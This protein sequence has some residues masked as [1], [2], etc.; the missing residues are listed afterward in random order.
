MNYKLA[1]RPS[2]EDVFPNDSSPSSQITPACA[3]LTET[4][5]KTSQHSRKLLPKQVGWKQ[6]S[7]IF[8]SNL[9]RG[10]SLEGMCCLPFMQQEL[11][12]LDKRMIDKLSR[13][14]LPLLGYYMDHDV[15]TGLRGNIIGRWGLVGG[16]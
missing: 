10:Q 14:L 4:E 2:Y 16:Y 8:V 7:L 12:Y 11:W 15:L 9:K 3:K 5:T 6:Y 1:Y 13:Q